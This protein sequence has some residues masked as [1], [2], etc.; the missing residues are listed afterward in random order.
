MQAMHSIILVIGDTQSRD[1]RGKAF[2]C[3][4]IFVSATILVDTAYIARHT[5]SVLF[6][7]EGVRDGAV[8]RFGLY[9]F[10]ICIV[11]CILSIS[12]SLE[13]LSLHSLDR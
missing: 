8:C 13:Q 11:L 6:C 3:P 9:S 10:D 5:H 4:Y 2:T 7:S 12:L 1:V